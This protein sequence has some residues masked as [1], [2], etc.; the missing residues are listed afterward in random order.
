MNKK[1]LEEQK[2]AFLKELEEEPPYD[3]ETF[4]ARLKALA[5]TLSEWAQM[6]P[7]GD[8][9]VRTSDYGLDGTHGSGGFTVSS[10]EDGYEQCRKEYGLDKPG[11]TRTIVKKLV[12]GVWVVQPE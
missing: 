1:D 12:A 9:V 8:I 3:K 7:N 11:D 2:A 6:Q 4:D 5:G 10:S